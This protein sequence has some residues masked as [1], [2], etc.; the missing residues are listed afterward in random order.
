MTGKSTP[1]SLRRKIVL[2]FDQDILTPTQVS[3]ETDEL[4]E[5]SYKSAYKMAA[6]TALNI[7]HKDNDHI[8]LTCCIKEDKIF[9]PAVVSE[10]INNIFS[11]EE[12]KIDKKSIVEAHFEKIKDMLVAKGI[13]A[14]VDIH[15][16][17]DSTATDII[18]AHRAN[19]VVAQPA[20]MSALGKTF[21]LDW[22]ETLSRSS[23]CPITIVR[24]NDI[25]DSVLSQ[26]GL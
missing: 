14:S 13:S 26:V 8:F 15:V 10:I 19:L 24:G 7:C 22:A 3:S 23:I 18:H 21:S 2:I 1:L 9:D 12:V 5:R 4:Y 17:N 25:D 20:E 11:D 16:G 6:W